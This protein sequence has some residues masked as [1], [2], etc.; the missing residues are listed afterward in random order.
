MTA[1]LHDGG[2]PRSLWKRPALITALLLVI[3]LMGNLFVNGWH[4]EFRG[5]LLIG[6]LLFAVSLAF[7][8]ITRNTDTPHY[9]AAVGIAMVTAVV[10]VWLNFIQAADDINPDAILY[11][12]VPVVGVAGAFM[13]RFRPVG[14]ARA[15]F[16]VA[17]VQASVLVMA[18]VIR[19]P[20]LTPWS[21]A[22]LRGFGFNA[23]FVVLFAV[24]ALRFRK[25][26]VSAP[27]PGTA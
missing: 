4:W 18:L 7:E 2:R 1:T 13:A 15:L 10:L 16:A 5:F 27:A 14:M 6:T 19:N 9:R 8:W 22:V 25:A 3:P 24:S 21:V 26:A 23:F 20:E 11:L 12:V 17:L